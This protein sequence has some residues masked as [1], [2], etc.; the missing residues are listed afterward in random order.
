M[1]DHG[2]FSEEPQAQW[3]TEPDVDRKME[4]LREFTFTDRSGK[5]W[6][7]PKTSKIDGASI[8]RPLWTLV[9]SPYTGEYRRASIVH[10]VACVRAKGDRRARRAAD[11]MFFH[12]CRAGGCGKLEAVLLYLGVRMGA[13]WHLVPQWAPAL[14]VATEGPRVARSPAEQQMESDYSRA[15]EILKADEPADDADDVERRVDEAL[16]V[17]ALRNFSEL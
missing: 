2:K 11:K 10:D 15:A 16:T 9:G 7:A 13:V 17:V 14:V 3:L 4:L 6:D 1:A 5:V 12:A 8:P